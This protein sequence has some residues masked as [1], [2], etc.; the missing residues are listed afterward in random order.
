MSRDPSPPLPE[1][2]QLPADRL[3]TFALAV[4]GSPGVGDACLQ[5]QD[6]GG[7]N[8][9][10]LLFVLWLGAE[11]GVLLSAQEMESASSLV[12]G[13]HTEI[14]GTL[15]TLRRR[16]KGGPPPAPAAE[17]DALREKIK[18]I[19]LAAERLELD[20]LARMAAGRKWRETTAPSAAVAARNLDLM[21]GADLAGQKWASDAV[22]SL[23]AAVR[24]RA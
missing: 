17:T 20:T 6:R 9:P 19:E 15:R 10:L 2:G 7:T 21:L 22:A 24:G 3:W 23:L 4:Y 12:G 1:P 5:L 8:I 18:A 14:V 13:W 11:R 16:L